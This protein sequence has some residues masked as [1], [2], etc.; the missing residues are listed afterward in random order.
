MRRRSGSSIVAVLL[1]LSAVLVL[2]MGLLSSRVSQVRAARFSM[3]A[4]QAQLLAE[5]GLA[6]ARLKLDKR[7]GFPPKNMDEDEVIFTYTEDFFAPDGVRVGSYHVI[8]DRTWEKDPYRLIRVTSEGFLGPPDAP[9]ARRKI[10]AEMDTGSLPTQWINW[11][12]EGG[13]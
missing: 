9:L 1:L 10:I 8:V 13:L 12:D 4:S 7:L 11:I 3:Q 5:S 6:D 2:G